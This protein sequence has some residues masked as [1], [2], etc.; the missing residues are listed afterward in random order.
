M[1]I[2]PIY[3]PTYIN[4]P[5]YAPARV[6]P[7]LLF[8]NGMINCE[9]Y[10][11]ESGSTTVGGT[12][13][14]QTAFPYFDNY[15][16]VT[17]SF[18]TVNSKSLLFYNEEAVYGEVP[19]DS[20]YSEYWSDYVNLLYNP[21]T[22]LLNA[23][24]IIPLADYFK[25]ELNDVVEFRGNYYH[26]RAVND[27]NLKNGECSL[28]LLGP[29]LPESLNLPTKLF[30]KCF[31]YDV[32]DCDIACYSACEC[33][34]TCDP[35]E[36]TSVD[37]SDLIFTIKAEGPF[38]PDEPTFV[39]TLPTLNTKNYDFTI[40]WGDGTSNYVSGSSSPN[41]SHV[42]ATGSYTAS[43]SGL[44]QEF[45]TD[46]VRLANESPRLVINGVH[47]FGN[48]GADRVNFGRTVN[49]INMDMVYAQPGQFTW[50]N[51]TRLFSGG[52][53]GGGMAIGNT[54]KEN[55]FYYCT[56]VRSVNGV[57]SFTK[58]LP[59]IPENLFNRCYDAQL[60][61]DAFR[62]ANSNFANQVQMPSGSGFI[63]SGSYSTFFNITNMF[64]NMR[65]GIYFYS[66]SFDNVISQAN[67]GILTATDFMRYSPGTN[68]M[69]GHAP[70]FWNMPSATVAGSGAFE[71]CT[72]LL[73]Y[74]AIPPGFK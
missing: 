25:I 9:S 50:E 70:E 35:F 15:N 11:I 61:S 74:A 46:N 53:A 14:E 20:L 34:G 57:F 22:K 21:R 3:I 59:N 45:N 42:Y 33:T 51:M 32:S 31:G 16:V 7:R 26:L 36:F 6:Q 2:I 17:G 73:N 8:Y 55:L 54:I 24:A 60:F 49:T 38:I 68:P 18:P 66:S 43:I 5:E 19:T 41:L 10:Y 23:S 27:Y 62:F 48:T 52:G 44:Y 72:N 39:F 37:V 69:S 13:F 4:S 12:A 30:A 65:E 40:N 67:S 1:A 47:Q 28:Q 64:M 29:I 58:V 56:N 71:N 63:S